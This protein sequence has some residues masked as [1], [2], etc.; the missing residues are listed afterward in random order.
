MKGILKNHLIDAG[1]TD[2]S[3]QP[4]V[5]EVKDKPYY[6]PKRSEIELYQEEIVDL[7]SEY[8]RTV[9]RYYTTLWGYILIGIIIAESGHTEVLC[10]WN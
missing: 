5:N 2:D 4:I 9:K 7:N 10:L 1:F 8:Y 6:I 3:Y